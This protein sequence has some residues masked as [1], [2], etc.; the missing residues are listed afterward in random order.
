MPTAANAESPHPTASRTHLSAVGDHG[1]SSMAPLFADRRNFP[2]ER[3]ERLDTAFPASRFAYFVSSTSLDD[4]PRPLTDE[5]SEVAIVNLRRRNPH[6]HVMQ[7]LVTH[8]KD[9]QNTENLISVKLIQS[10]SR[11]TI[12]RSLLDVLLELDE[13]AISLN[14]ALVTCRACIAFAPVPKAV[15]APETPAPKARILDAIYSWNASK[16]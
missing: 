14:D 11:R 5:E 15:V 16:Q 3:P 10:K 1:Q 12:R 4:T 2:Q 7:T 13:F 8:L 6:D 9:N